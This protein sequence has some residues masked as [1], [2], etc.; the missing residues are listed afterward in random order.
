MITVAYE[1]KI[2]NQILYIRGEERT[3]VKIVFI[4]G[5]INLALNVIL[6]QLKYFT[7][8]SSILTTTLAKGLLI[9]GEY[10]YVRF[11][12]KLKINLFSI[13][14][15]KYFFIPLLF[16]PIIYEIKSLI[17]NIIIYTLVSVGVAS[18]V[19]FGI[20]I[21]IKDDTFN[22]LKGIILS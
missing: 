9:I 12:L 18:I 21:V 4:T 11:K 13:Y 6:V 5:I 20:L 8:T 22:Y 14:K 15:L 16:I 10:L 1:N 3:Q 7:V 17:S 2:S 19:Y